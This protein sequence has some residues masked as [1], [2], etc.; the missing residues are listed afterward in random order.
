MSM[1]APALKF[2]QHRGLTS[3]VNHAY[4]G[5]GAL[6]SEA[7]ERS[8]AEAKSMFWVVTALL[9]AAIATLVATTL[10][11]FGSLAALGNT[12][13]AIDLIAGAL[14]LVLLVPL[15]HVAVASTKK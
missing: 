1:F 5:G 12:T 8:H 14:G 15:I 11:R 10:Q 2:W 9:F 7:I 13:V 4:F 6:M 3:G